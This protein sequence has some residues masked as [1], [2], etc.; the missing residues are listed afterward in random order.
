MNSSPN[1][2]SNFNM[3]FRQWH[4]TEM[5]KYRE[6]LTS[7]SGIISPSWQDRKLSWSLFCA[8]PQRSWV[9]FWVFYIC[10][11]NGYMKHFMFTSPKEKYHELSC[12]WH[13]DLWREGGSGTFT[14]NKTKKPFPSLQKKGP[15][16]AVGIHMMDE[17][18]ATLIPGVTGGPD[19]LSLIINHLHLLGLFISNSIPK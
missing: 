15:W 16:W 2:H 7:N 11:L 19:S 12:S 17:F 4:Y 13:I 14:K 18:L 3:D 9:E 6:T 5:C 1:I 8:S 10:C